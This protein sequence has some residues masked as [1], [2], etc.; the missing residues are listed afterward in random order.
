MKPVKIYQLLSYVNAYNKRTKTWESI[1][2]TQKIYAGRQGLKTALSEFE[3]EVGQYKYVTTVG[4]WNKYGDTRGKAELT[5]PHIHENGEIAYWGD[6][7]IKTH[8][9]Q[10]I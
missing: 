3:R 7:I 4:N 9:P 5:E 2:R 10:N 8:N 1:R 6:R